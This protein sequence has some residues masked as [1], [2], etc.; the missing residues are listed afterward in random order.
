MDDDVYINFEGKIVEVLVGLDSAKYGPFVCTYKGRRFMYAKAIYGTLRAALLFYQL[1]S[2]ELIKWGF[3]ANP[4]DACTMNKIVNGEQLTIVW[5]VDD[6]KISDKDKNV[7]DDT[8]RKL[9]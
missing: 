8:I 5:H 1:F 2:G 9:E 7:V 4:Y 3:V 6:C